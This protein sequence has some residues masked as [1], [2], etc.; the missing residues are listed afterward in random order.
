[1]N[2]CRA[3]HVA[4][5]GFGRIGV[6]TVVFALYT[7][8]V[9]SGAAAPGVV[10]AEFQGKWVAGNATCASPVGVLVEGARLTLVNGGDKEAFGGIEMAG[11]GYFAPGYHGIMA[12]LFTEFSGDQPVI[13][14]FNPAERKGAAQVEFGVVMPGNATPQLKAYNAHLAKLNL[15]KRFPLDKVALKKCPGA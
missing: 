2:H 7:A 14:T 12:V 8:A 10:P 13:V 15:A 1:M 4:G 9:A 11:P 5:S 6:L 3:N